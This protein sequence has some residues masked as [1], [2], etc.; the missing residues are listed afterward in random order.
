VKFA[1]TFEILNI[2]SYSIFLSMN[3]F[4]VDLHLNGIIINYTLTV[5]KWLLS[6]KKKMQN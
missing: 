6:S 1:G 2:I 5:F 4:C 3:R